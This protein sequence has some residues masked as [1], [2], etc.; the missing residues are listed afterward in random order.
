MGKHNLEVV[1]FEVQ[2]LR[3]IEGHSP[4]RVEWLKK[5]ILSEKIWKVPLALDDQHGFVLDGQHRMEVAKALN[6]KKVPVVEFSYSKVL[7]RSL[8]PKYNFEWQ[9]VV[10]RA[11][12]GNIYPYKTVKHDF[13]VPL[14]RVSYRLDELI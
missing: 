10:Q 2:R 7:V 4:K 6:L 11:L 8:R 3:H 9:D 5:K 1:L 14:P 13:I 12:Q